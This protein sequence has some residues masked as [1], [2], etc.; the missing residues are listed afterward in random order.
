M[1]TARHSACAAALPD[2]R[3]L[4]P[5][6]GSFYFAR[7][8]LRGGVGRT[9]TARTEECVLVAGRSLR[10]GSVLNSG[11]RRQ[12][13]KARVPFAPPSEHQVIDTNLPVTGF[14]AA[15]QLRHHHELQ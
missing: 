14:V 15:G 4:V 11:S 7:D 12:P 2:G 13:A 10:P 6:N 5:Q 9:C 1:L 3:I 8:M